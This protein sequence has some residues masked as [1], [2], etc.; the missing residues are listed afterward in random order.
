MV[1][2]FKNTN[3]YVRGLSQ[4]LVRLLKYQ[5]ARQRNR[6]S[7]TA[8][9]NSSGKLSASLEIDYDT[10]DGEYIY[11]IL[12]N[13]YGLNV[14]DDV[15]RSKMPPV[16]KIIDWIDT[17]PVT[18][19]ES[20]YKGRL[21]GSITTKKKKLAFAIAKK[22]QLKGINKTGF[23]NEAIADVMKKLAI[24]EPVIQDI[25][26]NLEEILIKAGFHETGNEYIIKR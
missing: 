12:G 7:V 20:K 14:D 25:E 26:N 6:G 1:N 13:E 22:I 11:Y 10:T 2:K 5:I 15:K 4:K 19:V 21:S 23:I 24:E 18:L 8:P 9:I 3:L 17:K 16:Q